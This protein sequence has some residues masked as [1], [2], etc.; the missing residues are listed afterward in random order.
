[1]AITMLP[2]PFGNLIGAVLM[3][4]Q[5]GGPAVR[6]RFERDL[7]THAFVEKM[8]FRNRKRPQRPLVGNRIYSR[9]V[10]DVTSNTQFGRSR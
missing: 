9:P 4:D 2:D 10:I 1:M 6:T 7:R 3:Q 5:A 8:P